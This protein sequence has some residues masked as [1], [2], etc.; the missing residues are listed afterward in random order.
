MLRIGVAIAAV[1]YLVILAGQIYDLATGS[2]SLSGV[3]VEKQS[4]DVV[5]VSG[6]RT[7]IDELGG[8]QI[9]DVILQIGTN[10]TTG[11]AHRPDGYFDFRYALDV[12]DGH[13]L[14]RRNGELREIRYD[15]QRYRW[16]AVIVLRT[17]AL[18]FLAVVMLVYS[19]GALAQTA[20]I[21]FLLTSCLGQGAPI[22]P[23]GSATAVLTVTW[24]LGQAI[25]FPGWIQVAQRIINPSI[26]R[27]QLIW[28][29]LLSVIGAVLY[30]NYTGVGLPHELPWLLYTSLVFA[31]LAIIL[32]LIHR[33]YRHATSIG[34]RQIQW[35]LTAAFT[36]IIM[37]AVAMIIDFLNA[38]AYAHAFL[39]VAGFGNIVIPIAFVI[40]ILKADVIPIDRAIVTT[41]TYAI[42][43]VMLALALEFLIEPLA[44]F[45]ST[46]LGMN[47]STG[48]TILIV[49]IALGAPYAKKRL[50]PHV[51]WL[52]RRYE[53]E[54]QD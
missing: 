27:Q 30:M 20:A 28:P 38:D 10:D 49:G 47:E 24:C 54:E 40:G 5:Q 29:W 45:A 44:G 52:L 33:G 17:L 53:T 3:Y 43:V 18:G 16:P 36:T 19:S 9:G 39:F 50:R 51:V 34:R 32:W 48:Q 25:C 42:I 15:L 21:T 14:I 11:E 13:M 41:A 37:L 23:N 6:F 12:A 8:L 4:A 22:G 7:G 31:M 26:S 46:Y 1:L 35:V 2:G